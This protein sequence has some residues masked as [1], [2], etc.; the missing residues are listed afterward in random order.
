MKVRTG[1][2]SNSSSS[3]FCIYGIY[4]ETEQLNLIG[5]GENLND[6]VEKKLADAG[7]GKVGIVYGQADDY[8]YLGR[9]YLDMGQDE[10][11]GQFEE[12]VRKAVA[13]LFPENTPHCGIHEESWYDG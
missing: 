7:L 5:D 2:V 13:L 10:T 1:F 4:L 6:E 8:G 12:G 9:D 3:S 11:R